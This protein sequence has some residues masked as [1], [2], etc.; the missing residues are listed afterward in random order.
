M[1]AGVR[2]VLDV[3][4]KQSSGAPRT[5]IETVRWFADRQWDVEVTGDPAYCFADEAVHVKTT[6]RRIAHTPLRATRRAAPPPT[7]L[8]LMQAEGRTD[9]RTRDGRSHRIEEGHVLV[10]PARDVAA[11]Q[12]AGPSARIE[13]EVPTDIATIELPERVVLVAPADDSRAVF[14]L[15]AVVISSLNATGRVSPE[16]ATH[17]QSAIVHLVGAI[18][19]ELVVHGIPPLADETRQLLAKA[20]TLIDARA[21]SHG[22]TVR[23][24]ASELGVTPRHL[25][26]VFRAA[27]ASPKAALTQRRALAA[28]LLLA[29]DPD[30]SLPSIARASGFPS[31]TALRHHLAR[32]ST[33]HQGLGPS[34]G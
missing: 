9:L 12:T 29:G 25:A 10:C 26:R 8:V 2:K 27:F 34:D 17:V 4:Q 23:S 11:V 33:D 1:G 31:A 16:V 15:S 13:I 24:L 7:I 18:I 6:V 20:L 32:E 21:E 30:A 5:S 28:Q 3:R 14:T 22:V 19:N